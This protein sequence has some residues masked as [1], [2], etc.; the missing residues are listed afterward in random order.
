LGYD[1]QHAKGKDMN[2]TRLHMKIKGF[3][4][5]DDPLACVTCG[6]LAATLMLPK[7]QK[8]FLSHMP[9]PCT[10]VQTKKDRQGR[11][12]DEEQEVPFMFFDFRLGPEQWPRGVELID[13]EKAADLLVRLLIMHASL[14]VPV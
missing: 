9:I 2:T 1:L 11:E 7:I 6:G 10:H 5:R 13:A 12:G 4:H 3:V 8:L 14:L